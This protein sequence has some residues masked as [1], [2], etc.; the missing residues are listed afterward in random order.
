MGL[1]YIRLKFYVYIVH[2]LEVKVI[3][4]ELQIGLSFGLVAATTLTTTTSSSQI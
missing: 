3:V 1:N 2:L 4:R